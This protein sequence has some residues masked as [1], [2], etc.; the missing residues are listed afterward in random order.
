FDVMFNLLEG[1]FQE[2]KDSSKEELK[3]IQ[4][5]SKFDLSLT[6]L[7]LG[8]E[9]HLSLEYST[10]LFNPETIERFINYFRQ[11]IQSLSGKQE[12]K[13]KNLNILPEAEKQQLLYK[14]NDTKRDYPKDK[15]IHQ[16]FEEQ[17]ER[18]PDRIALN[19]NDQ[20]ITY[21]ELNSR[22]N[23]LGQILLEK[24]VNSEDIV[25]LLV[26]RSIEMLI[27]ILGI[28]KAGG[29]YLPIDPSHPESRIKYILENSNSQLILCL[30]I[31]KNKIDLSFHIFLLEEGIFTKDEKSNLDI[32][33][34]PTNLCYVIYTSGST[35]TPK[36]VNI[37][38]LSVLNLL[39]FLQDKY[40]IR[41]N[42]SYLLKTSYCFDV[43]ISELF[44][45]IQGGG[46]LCILET[47]HE[48]DAVKI[49]ETINKSFVTHINFVPSVFN[50]FSESIPEINKNKLISLRYILLAGEALLSEHLKTFKSYGLDIQIDNLYGPTE[51]TVFASYYKVDL[52]EVGSVSIGRPLSN[53]EIYI[54]DKNLKLQA[55]GVSGEL[56]IGGKGLAR[57][58]L[59]NLELTTEKFIEH[60]FK[61]GEKLYKTGDLAR[62]LPDG[63]IEFL[64][65]I[66]DQVKIR[67]FRIELGEIENT[68]LRYKNI[69]ESVVL[70][71]GQGE[72]KYL[73]AYVVVE[74][75]FN[76]EE[77]RNY[78]SEHLPNYMIPTYF[79]ALEKIPL[80][81]NGKIDKKSLL[82]PEIKAG[83]DYVA[84][85]N[86]IETKLVKIWSEVLNVVSKEISTHVSFF[87]L[88]GHSL[89][90]TVLVS[91]IH[92]ELDVRLE[93]Q[94]IFKYQS[95]QG[96][97]ELISSSE[98]SSY[99]SI[100]KA[101]N[102][103]YYPLSSS[104]RRLYLLQQ[105]DLGS[106]AYNMPGLL[107]VPK[108]KN[109]HQITAVFH[110]LIDRHE[111]FRTS[112]EVENE[113]PV[114]RIH[115]EV[116]FSIKDYQITNSELLKIKEDF[117]QAF[118]LSLSPLLRVGYLEISDGDDMLLVDMH[119][120][121]SD[122][123]SYAILEKEF[124]QL[125]SG[126]E[127][128]P[129][130][131][132]YKDYSQ[133]QNSTE[134]QER[135]KGQ[136]AYWLDKFTDE[137]PVLEIPTDYSRP[138]VQSFEG[139]S[140]GFVLSPEETKIIHEISKEQGLTLY[141]S[142]LS[143]FTILLSKL[144]GLEDIIVGSP[145]AARRHADLEDI[146]G[147]FVNTLAIRSDVSR[148][149]RLIDYLQELKEN[150][151]EAYENQEY[152]FEDLIDKVVENRDASRNP[153][154]DVMFNLLEG[155][156]QEIKDSSKEELIHNS[157]TSKFDLNLTALNLGSEIEL[158]LEYSTNLFNPETIEQ[159][160]KY[161]K[162]IIKE[163]SKDPYKLIGEIKII[164]EIEE[165]Y[166]R[167]LGEGLKNISKNELIHE[168]FSQKV[169][170]N[171][172]NVA[173]V[174]NDKV[175][176]YRQLEEKSNSLARTLRAKGV[177]ANDVIGLMV[178]RSFEMIIG[179]L[180]ILKSGGAC[181]PIDLNY[182]EERKIYMLKDCE[183]KIV[184]KN[185]NLE[186]EKNKPL[187]FVEVVDLN[188]ESNYDK[189]NSSLPIINNNKDLFYVIY[190][191]GSTGQPK[192]V[193]LEHRNLINLI[194]NNKYVNIELEK[195][196]QFNSISF[197][198]SFQEIFSTL[199]YGG[200]LYLIKDD[201]R[202]E[203]PNLF[204][205]V[206][207]HSISTVFFPTA[208]TKTIFN[209]FE[210]IDIIPSCIKHVVT[211]GEQ[212]IISDVFRNYLKQKQIYLHNHYGPSETHV[213]TTFTIEPNNKISE[214][215]SIGYPIQNTSI[216]ILD[217]F[218]NIQP[219]GVSGELYIEG[220]SVG[221]GYFGRDLLTSE[222]FISHPFKEGERLYRT[223]DLARLLPDGNIEF[224]GRLDHQVKIRGFRIELG[225]IESNIQKYD[226]VKDVAVLARKDKKGD[227]YLCAYVV[228]KKELK[229][230]IL[231]S[232]LTG[233]L[234]EYM[235]PSYFVALENIPLTSNGK[236]DKKSL[237]E[238]EVKAGGA[239]VAPKTLIESK[240]VK[241]WSEVLNVASKEISTNVSFFELGGHS[242]KATVLVSRIHKELDV[243]LELRD[244]FKYQNIQGQSVLINS[245]ENTSYFSIPKTKIQEY[246]PLSS[247]QRRLY[248]L[249][250]MDLEGTAYNMPG[251]ISVPKDYDKHQIEEVFHKLIARHENFRTS[252]EVEN[253][254]PVQRIHSE[255]SFSIKSYQIT[256]TELSNVRENFVHA[257]DL[258]H[259]PLLRVG[260]LEIID[261]DDMLL[262]DM[263]HI[264]SDG[265]SHSILEEDFS[266]LLLGKELAPLH[267]QYKDYSQWQN[268]KEQQERIN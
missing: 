231:R 38:H 141:M 118:D 133:W 73:C 189:D 60:P 229:F 170:E 236:I 4:G 144:S 192:G 2:E 154:F 22:S 145:I 132:K 207:K 135:I 218:K 151:L 77:I 249:Q 81:R 244:I 134:Q 225:E 165:K 209:D 48:K 255:V 204:D 182:P 10:K 116:T 5:I 127:L 50:S 108:G 100:P 40:P 210:D 70:V 93:L 11:L 31:Y 206:K 54:L 32:P 147:M 69:K 228:G 123:R 168:L 175:I 34:T 164:T 136:E 18:T 138:L 125:I 52:D 43:S 227:N 212:L 8:S 66:D 143:I 259:A 137:L 94:D 80:T 85:N 107:A 264:I 63:N 205:L 103:D 20:I 163:I 65:R 140:V 30:E 150:T 180:G 113:M 83:S 148:D 149:K 13:I 202:K 256:N 27:G 162:Q 131:L 56:L 153:I 71:W 230:E 128:A 82:A 219:I 169:K 188:K 155:E 183:V 124:N 186:K 6:A 201:E 161:F 167:N 246:Y 62:W 74:E 21:R 26:D 97:S 68:L 200:T 16:L 174:F 257:F 84:P 95:I 117:V 203:I 248:L 76:K 267:L 90:A 213:V 1:E 139:A 78:L 130:H 110:K 232:Y 46:K 216:F 195:V 7:D 190:T 243:R 157:G 233:I 263:H 239:Y 152:Q 194:E 220:A 224:L 28:L 262:V 109:K 197:D 187:N 3:H 25:G 121:I 250:Q 126:K 105:M 142:L 235:I 222:K 35:G 120:I 67:G 268:S 196:L 41:I 44:G 29:A 19:Y 172:L 226:D 129:L 266:Q 258:S 253:E 181:L 215:P 12:Q 39:Y 36:G 23:Q 252:F 111:N 193:M 37:E 159:F 92:K 17:V 265:R 185:E 146:V 199:L 55:V 15:T 59:N 114:Q 47:G 251:L 86:L 14:F 245:S 96:Q 178:E 211:A 176:S 99:L 64:G 173:L 214:F 166:I 9:I 254:L 234:P 79:V 217:R 24:G 237:P 61:E 53:Y 91:R 158:N 57:N 160:I 208:Y 102:Q 75:T 260:Y 177:K 223:G 89:K 49:I 247:S 88:G 104:Q 72:D 171:P 101:K 184:L 51:A 179:I 45:W 191:S 198:V 261:G 119:H 156:S 238:P 98:S 58:Y 242:L 115:S 241:I 122:G 106:T 87:E 112:F 42:D 33:I 240:L 221:R